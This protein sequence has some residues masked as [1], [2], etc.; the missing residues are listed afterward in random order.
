MVA[1]TSAPAGCVAPECADPDYRDPECRVLVENEL[2]AL[3]AP[4]GL[5]VRFVDPEAPDAGGWVAAGLVTRTAPS[6]VHARVA[7][8]GSF[9]LRVGGAGALTLVLDNVDPAAT[10]VARFAGQELPI[11]GGAGLRRAVTLDLS[12][13]TE[14]EIRGTRACPPRFRLAVTSDLHGNLEQT[15]RILRRLAEERAAAEAAGE[16]LVGLVILGDLSPDGTI[17]QLAAARDALEAS[18]VP[19]AAGIGNHD[20]VDG[21]GPTFNRTF[22]PGNYAF[23]VCDLRAAQLDTGAGGLAPS[24]EARLPELLDRRGARFQ[25]V[26]THI[27]P[28]PGRTGGGWASERQAERLLVEAAIQDNDAVLAGHV[29]A[30]LSFPLIPVGD[31][32]V[33]EFVVGTGGG[34]Q[35]AAASRFGY[36]RLRFA[37][38]LEACF[39]EVPPAGGEPLP[40]PPDGVP[41]CSAP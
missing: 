4:D 41:R 36:L 12:P 19:V 33:R 17:D 22:G 16:A 3:R 2:A 27:P 40:R 8:P 25:V 9:A 35:G 15:A 6:E 11:A 28:Y 37:E 30:V 31:A 32:R 21:D 10:V 29:H 26:G 5:D 13:E 20:V 24:I 34:D 39:V 38:E 14:V 18:P 23:S 7:A 1:A